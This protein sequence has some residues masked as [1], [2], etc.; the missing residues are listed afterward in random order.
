MRAFIALLRDATWLTP[1]RARA[2]RNILLVVFFAAIVATVALSRGGMDFYG[3]P[4]G[5]D[6]ISFWTAS[7][8][9]LAGAP[10]GAYDVGRHWAAQKSAFGGIPL[11]YTAFFYPP[12]FLLVCL[13][14]AL[15]P[16]FWSLAAWL[17]VT[18]GLCWAAL[19][20][21]ARTIDPPTLPLPLREGVG[22]GGDADVPGKLR[23]DPSPQ[24]PPARG[25]GESVFTPVGIIRLTRGCTLAMLAFPGTWMN[26]MHGQNGFLT[27][28]LFAGAVATLERHP[29]WAGILL[30]GLIY[31]PH[32]L[33]MIPVVL[34]AGRRWTTA[35]SAVV[36]AVLLCGLSLAVLGA[37]AWRGFLADSALARSALEQ[38][39]VGNDKMQSVFAAVRLLGGGLVTAYGLQ[40]V[41]SVVVAAVLA[42]LSRNAANPR[43]IGAA[44]A[45]GTLLATPFLLVYDMMLLAIPLIWMI[46]Q[47]GLTGFRPWEKTV[48]LAAFVMPLVSAEL[49]HFLSVPIAP[50]VLMMVFAVVV[51][52]V[53]KPINSTPIGLH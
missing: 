38:D 7:K 32:F 25:A 5:T 23:I 50:V 24:P 18:G 27:T 2:Y 51:R 47:A 39:L 16:Y 37:D 15:L 36:T 9:A 12:V 11:D 48:L 31:K 13:P 4:L 8:I 46:G 43:G 49:A 53:W 14:L 45:C 6:F 10:E 29:V 1:D 33:L 41:L 52:R 42:W 17:G 22:G 40:A 19:I 20:P 35:V 21:A 3:R 44:L 34:I 28:A 26:I 30:G